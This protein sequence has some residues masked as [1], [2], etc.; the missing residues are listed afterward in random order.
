MPH[1][2]YQ[3]TKARDELVAKLDRAQLTHEPEATVRVRQVGT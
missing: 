3:E 2:N 1:A